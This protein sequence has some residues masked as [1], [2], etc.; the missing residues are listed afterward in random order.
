MSEEPRGRKT[1]LA[2]RPSTYEVGYGKPPV[3]SRFQAGRSGNPKGRPKGSRNRRPTP[4][5]ENEQLRAIILSEAYRSVPINDSSGTTTIPM[6]QAIVRSMAVNAAK[7]SQRAQKLFTEL[8]STRER[9]DRRLRHA[10]LEAAITYK[11]EWER[12]LDRRKRLGIVAPDPVPHPDHVLIDVDTG[13][14]R[15]AGPMTKEE[16]GTWELWRKRE[17]MLTRELAELEGL[18]G[19]PDCE[20]LD[21]IRAEKTK[22]EQALAFIDAALG[23]SRRAL[24]VLQRLKIPEFEE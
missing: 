13:F 23:G 1:A 11:V 14:V 10:T 4:E 5:R 15:F 9:E 16:Q 18:L 21:E 12:E 20:D 24:Q 2:R 7:G 17:A 19:D 3:E 22:T 6:A 8:L